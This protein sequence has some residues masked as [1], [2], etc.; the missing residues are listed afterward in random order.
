MQQKWC[1]TDR[2]LYAIK[3]ALESTASI[4]L[5]AKVTVHTD[6]AALTHLQTTPTPKL[7][8]YGLAIRNYGAE[9]VHV[10]GKENVTADFLSRIEGTQVEDSLTDGY[11]LLTLGEVTLLTVESL[12][13]ECQK[14]PPHPDVEVRNGVYYRRLTHKL[15]IPPKFRE[16]IMF[17]A[18][19]HRGGHMGVGK[20]VKTL[21]R[22]VWWPKLATD[23]AEFISA[24]LLCQCLRSEPKKEGLGTFDRVKISELVSLDYVGPRRIK[25]R[26]NYILVAIDHYTRFAMGAT[27]TEPTAEF[28]WE[29]GVMLGSQRNIV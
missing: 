1:A 10:S 11:A 23:V 4:F 25:G 19:A 8:R 29:F 7:I 3:W 22:G 2:E 15:Y 27:T 6:H 18:H 21:T 9:I 14:E 12:A 16:Q 26:D 5:G 13:E 28:A 24:C 17:L 20:T